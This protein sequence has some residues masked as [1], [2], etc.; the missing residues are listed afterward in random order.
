MREARHFGGLSERETTRALVRAKQPASVRA[1]PRQWHGVGTAGCS[2]THSVHERCDFGCTACYLGSAAN[3]TSPLPF[4]AVAAQLDAIRAHLGPG[5]NV[6]ITS[7]EV[8]LLPREALARIVRHALAIGLDPM[9]MSHGQTF[10][11]DPSYL[12]HLVHA[13]LMKV[14]LH[15]DVTQRGRDGHAR[16]QSEAEL[17]DVR[18]ALANLI[19]S[20][21][22][23]TT[24]P[25]A[26]SHTMT[27][28]AANRAD[29]AEVVR[30]TL[31]NS[32]AFRMLSFQPVADVGRTRERTTRGAS[33][34]REVERG[35]GRSLSPHTFLMGHPACNRLCLAFVVAIGSRIEVLEV[36]RENAA[37][38]SH[39]ID[40]L[41]SGAFRHLYV[42]GARPTE[43]IGRV[44]GLLA[45][46]PEYALTFP[47]YSL[48]RLAGELEWLPAFLRAAAR[49]E[50]SVRPFV[51]VVHDF[52][53]RDELD[54]EEGLERLDACVFRVPVDGEMVSMCQL[55][56]SGMRDRLH[57]D[58]VR[59]RR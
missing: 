48:Y 43:V 53:S 4:S 45:R 14:G 22:R 55:N 58:L 15:V 56:G 20:V 51:F 17:H 21:R 27:V 41:A 24:R 30:W 50:A 34:W 38:D 44:L 28:G 33:V 29:V 10:L 5:G 35:A 40:H 23:R 2:A 6:Q 7:G 25:L 32:D 59:P 19:R 1:L 26:A 52:M 47:A 11:R 37:I 49:G 12:E 13:G 16:P 46:S 36:A 42:D 3:R 31:K 57:T 18:D 39:F 54:S 8:T 9:V